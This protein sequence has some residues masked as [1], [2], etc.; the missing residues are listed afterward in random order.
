M[1]TT[2]RPVLAQFADVEPEDWRA[3][4]GDGCAAEHPLVG[5]RKWIHIEAFRGRLVGFVDAVDDYPAAGVGH[6]GDV[7]R[8]V[9]LAEVL[10]GWNLS[11]QSRSSDSVTPSA[12]AWSTISLV[13][14]PGLT[15]N[16]LCSPVNNMVRRYRANRLNDP[17][18]PS[19]RTTSIRV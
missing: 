13:R 19:P 16:A 6:R 2:P 18:R 12:T 3:D 14:G 10:L 5:F 7:F 1:A 15:P 4:G 11:F 9:G 17:L 8:E